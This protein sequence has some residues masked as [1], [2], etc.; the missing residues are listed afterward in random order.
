MIALRYRNMEDETR[1]LCSITVSMSS[2]NGMQESTNHPLGI[3]TREEGAEN[4]GDITH[5]LHHPVIGSAYSSSVSA[6]GRTIDHEHCPHRTCAIRT[7]P[8]F[9]GRVINT[10]NRL[11][12]AWGM[13]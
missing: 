4:T 9:S 7:F 11:T 5:L 3:R 6:R 1:I 2:K 12:V 13:P 10:A 8:H